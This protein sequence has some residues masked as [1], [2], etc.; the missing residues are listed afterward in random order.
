MA[1]ATHCNLKAARRHFSCSGL[2]LRGSKCK[3]LQIHHLRA[4]PTRLRGAVMHQH[5]TVGNPRLNYNDLQI[6]NLGAVW[7]DFKVSGFQ[8]SRGLGGPVMHTCTKFQQN[9]TICC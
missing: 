5:S 7:H 3:S 4:R 1:I 6:E 2:V 9:P 8:S